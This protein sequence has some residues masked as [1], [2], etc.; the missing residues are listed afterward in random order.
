M[1]VL[2]LFDGMA[3]GM[4]AFQ[5]A[6]IF[7]D[8]YIAFEIDKYAIQT[9]SHNFPMIE[10]RGDVTQ[11]DFTEFLGYD[12]LVGGLPV[13]IGVLHKRTIEKQR[14]AVLAGSY[15]VNMFVRCMKRNHDTSSMKT[16]NQC[17]K[18]FETASQVH[19]G[20]NRFVSIPL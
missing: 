14:R 9:S 17:R 4:L 19:S 5:D 11:A 18:Q 6:N 12:F 10:H 15:S 8:K 1:K 16:T 2:S 13:P 20:L 7:V 3:C